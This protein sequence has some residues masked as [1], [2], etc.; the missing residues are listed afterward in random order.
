MTGAIKLRRACQSRRARADYRDFFS[1]ALY[2]RLGVHPSLREAVIDDRRFYIL[3]GHRQL[4]ETEHAGTFAGR[5][6]DPAGKFGKVVG[7]VQTFERF[8]PQA[9]INKIVP[10]RNQ[11]IDRAA[12]GHAADELS[13]VAEWN[14]AIHAARALLL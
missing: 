5:R 10:F 2:R 12:R 6:T 3:D 1:C 11:I 9:A 8:F 14:T 7:L 13:G 4:V